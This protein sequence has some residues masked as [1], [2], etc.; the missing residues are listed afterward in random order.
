MNFLCDYETIRVLL[1]RPE[2]GRSAYWSRRSERR[3]ERRW[4]SLQQCTV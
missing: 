3:V 1:F 2:V 4:H